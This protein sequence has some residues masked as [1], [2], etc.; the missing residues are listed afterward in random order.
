MS[1]I[2]NKRSITAAP[3]TPPADFAFPCHLQKNPK[4]STMKKIL[5]AIPTLIIGGQ[6]ALADVVY[7]TARPSPSGAGAN[8]DGT[9]S[10]VSVVGSDTSAVGNGTGA[11]ARA[12]SRFFSNTFSNTSYA[13]AFPN[14]GFRLTPTLGTPGG[15][16]QIHHNFS[17]TAGNVSTNISLTVTCSIGGTLSFTTAG[18]NFT[19]AAGNPASQWKFL[20]YVTN[21]V[22]SA[23]PSIDFYYLD[24]HVNAGLDNRLLV[25]AFRFTLYEPCADIAA[26]SVTGPLSTNSNQVV[27]TGISATATNVS[28]YQNSGSGMV[29]IGS[30]TTGVTAGNNTVTVSGLVKG[31]Q[32]AA[33]QTINGQEGCVPASGSL[34]GGFNPS[35]R[36]VLSIRETTSTGPVGTS[37]N[38]AGIGANIHFLGASTRIG[39]APGDGPVLTPDTSWQT[40]SF[41]RGTIS[42]ANASNTI[43]TV[44]GDIGYNPDDTIA[45]QVYA[46][47]YVPETSTTIFSRIAAQSSTLTSNDFFSVN[48]TWDAVPGAEGYRLLRSYNLDSYTNTYTD[49]LTAGFL[50]SNNQWS[51]LP[52][53][54]PV[55]P[56]D[57]QTN[58]SVKWNAA[59][60]SATAAG[61]QNDLRGQWGVLDAIAFAIDDL[62]DTGPFDIYIDNL[63]NGSTVFQTFE[64]AVGN[65]S[66]YGLRSP[67]NSGTTS[68]NILTAPDSARISVRAA[69]AGLKSLHIKYQWNG[70]NDTK[71]LRLTTS[72]ALGVSNPQ[73]NLDEL[74]TLRVLYLPA[75]ATPVAPTPPTISIDRNAANQQVLNWPG[76]HNLQAASVVTGTYTNVPSVTTAPWTNTFTDPAKFFRLSNPLDF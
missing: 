67:S 64:N 41:D 11:P 15:I 47:R 10:E 44:T 25:D 60:G 34:V 74:T 65:T 53:F 55:S 31:A 51:G 38:T 22:G 27:V 37:G 58:A 6:L 56:S 40:L 36:V 43:G 73:I 54:T 32:V 17:S 21:D 18:T 26:V 66:D 8:T 72:G 70:T 12:G 42:I 63:Q 76:T 20:G 7:I 2:V 62:G 46:Y 30:K 45:V 71:W 28:V 33:T 5:L 19:R 50:D 75:G 4:P 3:A 59:A 24:G 1:S 14:P 23:T 69:D 13:V 61:A 68:G 48:W 39:G 57:T 52:S 16:Y 35:L 9:Y 29:F 49:V